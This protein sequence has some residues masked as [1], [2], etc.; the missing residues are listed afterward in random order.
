[1]SKPAITNQIRIQS[2]RDYWFTVED[3]YLD[4][5]CDGL[6]ISYWSLR[7]GKEERAIYVCIDES[8]VLPVADAIYKLFKKEESDG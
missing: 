3:V 7:D 2:E 5:G 6:T 4:L 1:M 8:A